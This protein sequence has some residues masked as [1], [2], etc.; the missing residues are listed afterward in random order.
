MAFRKIRSEPPHLSLA[1]PVK[2]VHY[3]PKLWGLESRKPD[4]LK[5]INGSRGLCC[6]NRLMGFTAR[7]QRDNSGH[8]Q[9]VPCKIQDDKLVVLQ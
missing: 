5:R 4:G 3:A 1:Q 7:I 8:E 9:L 2:F 6:T